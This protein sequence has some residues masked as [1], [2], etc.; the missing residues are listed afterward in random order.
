MT[1][2]RSSRW[3]VEMQKIGPMVETGAPKTNLEQ[4]SLLRTGA[5]VWRTRPLVEVLRFR[6]NNFRVNIGASVWR[7][8]ALVGA[9]SQ[10]QL[11]NSF[12]LNLFRMDV[13]VNKGVSW[14]LF[15]H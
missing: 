12:C 9:F 2:L 3:S 4:V 10:G 13:W 5:P 15:E 8:G 11:K 6:K 14:P 1:P 7:T